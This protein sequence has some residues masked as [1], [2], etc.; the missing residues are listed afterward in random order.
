MTT[1]WEQVLPRDLRVRLD[2]LE[3]KVRTSMEELRLRAGLPMSVTVGGR[4]WIPVPWRGQPLTEEDLRRVLE[5]AGKGSLHA[6]LDQLR[7]GYV[8]ASGGVRIGVCGDAAVEDGALRAFRTVTSLAL[9]IPHPASGI[10]RPLLPR[11][12]EHGRLQSSLLIAPPGLGKTT[13][14]R[15]LIRCI[16]AGDGTAPLRVGVADQ[17]GELGAGD[18]RLLLGPRTDVLENVPKAAAL[19]MLLRGMSPQVLAADEITAPEDIRAMETAAGC[20]AVLLATAHGTDLTD[21]DRR[22]LYRDLLAAGIFRRFVV[23]RLENGR[24]TYTV[25]DGEGRT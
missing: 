19:L 12:T 7:A 9:R 24:R 2:G 13:L 14:L 4:E 25:S 21:L 16:S 17:R 8:T 10:A 20:G 6:I 22:P 1:P 23:V 3:P 15:D 11:L 18:L 5:V